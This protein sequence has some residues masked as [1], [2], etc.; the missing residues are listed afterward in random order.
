[1]YLLAR[2]VC[3]V[4][5]MLTPAPQ[6]YTLS[7]HDALPISY[8][9]VI[10]PMFSA[11]TRTRPSKPSSSRRSPVVM[12]RESEAGVESP[13]SEGKA[14]C[15]RS[16]EHTSELQSRENLVCRLLLEKKKTKKEKQVH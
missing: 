10:A 5:L 16:E 4:V 8:P 3:C 2:V 13:V 14:M 6:I 7:L 9:S 11:S 1:C 12:A 15:A